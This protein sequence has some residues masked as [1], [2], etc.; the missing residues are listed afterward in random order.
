MR[1]DEARPEGIFRQFAQFKES[2]PH[3]FGRLRVGD[4]AFDR[5]Q[6]ARDARSVLE[7]LVEQTAQLMKRTGE[8]MSHV[9]K[10]TSLGG[11]AVNLAEC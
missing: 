1:L 6:L 9:Y 2:R 3:V 4:G 5:V 10:E 7:S 11:L 8:D